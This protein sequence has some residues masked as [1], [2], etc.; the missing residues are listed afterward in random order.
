MKILVGYH[1]SDVSEKA[2]DLAR[3]HAKAFNAKMYILHSKVTDLPQKA[4]EI[5]KQNLEKVKS[6]LEKE[7]ISCETF[8]TIVNK[9]PGEH[10]VNFAEENEID[11]IIVGVRMKSK[12]GK[13]ILGSTAQYLVLK[14]PCPVVTVK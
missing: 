12:V 10:L 1:G 8:L 14:A 4:H 6:S 7:N 2:L 5:D 11:E 9:S 3:E 13:L